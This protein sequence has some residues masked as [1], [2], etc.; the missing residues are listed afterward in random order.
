[1]TQSCNQQYLDEALKEP[2]TLTPLHFN[3]TQSCNQQ[4][5]DEALKE[6][7]TLTPLHFNMTQSCNQQYLDEAL[8]EPST[9]TLIERYCTY[10]KVRKGHLGK[11]AAFWMS[12]TTCCHHLIIML[13][14]SVKTINIQLFH[15]CNGEM[16]TLFLTFD[17][18]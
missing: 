12:F 15:K 18:A 8:K 2:S 10:E 13:L 9:L 6:P 7:S 1:M 3:M 5:L 14:H 11:T 16:A 4:Y 17:G